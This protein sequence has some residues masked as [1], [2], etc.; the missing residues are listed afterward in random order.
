[1]DV[2]GMDNPQK[3]GMLQKLYYLRKEIDC[4]RILLAY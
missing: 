1:M 4:F 2:R 3:F